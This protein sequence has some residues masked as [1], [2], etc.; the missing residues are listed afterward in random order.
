[1]RKDEWWKRGRDTCSSKRRGPH[2]F[3]KQEETI[4][5]IATPYSSTRG[6]QTTRE[7]KHKEAEPSN[8]E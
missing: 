4:H 5:R 1:V 7:R 3:I 2:H 8:R 6:L